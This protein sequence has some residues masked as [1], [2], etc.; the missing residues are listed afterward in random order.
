DNQK[1]SEALYDYQVAFR[2]PARKL[3]EKGKMHPQAWDIRLTESDGQRMLCHWL[4]NE[5]YAEELIGWVKIPYIPPYAK[6]KVFLYYGNPKAPPSADGACTFE[7]FDDFLGE[8]LD[9]EKWEIHGNGQLKI[10]DSQAH[11]N[12]EE[13]DILIR[14]QASFSMPI[15]SEMKVLSCTGKYLAMALLKDQTETPIWEGYTLGLDE[16]RDWMT[17]AL[18]QSDFT[19][20]GGYDYQPMRIRGKITEEHLGIWSLSWITRNSIFA[21]LGGTQIIEPNAIWVIDQL[22]ICLG[23]LACNLGRAF[24]GQLRVDWVRLRKFAL[25]PPDT[26]L[27]E[28]KV[29]PDI[30]GLLDYGGHWNG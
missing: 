20:C 27:G 19:P 25:N 12:G 22:D 28:E 21:D 30:P 9:Q 1:S 2:I 24:S 26:F 18:N 11:F 14:S 29:N 17:L 8:S 15:I 13:A 3:I 7:S 16:P 23:V 4:E 5:P 10:Q 6:K